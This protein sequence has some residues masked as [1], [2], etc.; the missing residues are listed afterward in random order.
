MSSGKPSLKVFLPDSSQIETHR[1][2]KN[3]LVINTL[4]RARMLQKLALKLLPPLAIPPNGRTDLAVMSADPFHSRISA[5]KYAW[6]GR[7]SYEAV[8]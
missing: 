7:Y 5:M 6:H 3:R 2:N 8:L 4:Q 1:Q